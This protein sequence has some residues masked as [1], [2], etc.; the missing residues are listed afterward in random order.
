[1]DARDDDVAAELRV[2][3]QGPGNPDP[4]LLVEL[5]LRRPGIEVALQPATLLAQRVELLET[6]LDRPGPVG[7][8]IGVQAAV[9]AAAHDHAL[10]E[11]LPEAGRQR[12]AALVI[13]RVLVLAEKH[14]GPGPLSTTL[15]HDK[16]QFPT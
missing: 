6:R 8:R 11:R 5:T 13:D 15:P 10:R 1:G 16:P 12:E 4:A 3:E 9:Q 2:F 7:A 14:P